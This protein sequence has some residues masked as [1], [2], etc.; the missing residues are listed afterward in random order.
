[1][2]IKGI[3][4]VDVKKDRKY[5]IIIINDNG[6]GMSEELRKNIFNPFLPQRTRRLGLGLYIVYNIIKAH[7]G[8]IEV[9]SIEGSGSSF[10]IYI[11]KDSL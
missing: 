10:N 4:T 8:Y 9:E 11:R 7:G 6:V 3:I 5:A 1:M 2:E